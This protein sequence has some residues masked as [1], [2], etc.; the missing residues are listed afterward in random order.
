M[1]PIRKSLLVP[2][3]STG[4]LTALLAASDWILFSPVSLGI[5]MALLGKYLGGGLPPNV[6]TNIDVDP[7]Q[8]KILLSAFEQTKNVPF[9][10]YNIYDTV[11]DKEKDLYITK[12]DVDGVKLVLDLSLD[13]FETENKELLKAFLSKDYDKFVHE[14]ELSDKS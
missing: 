6:I 11:V 10:E 4:L 12:L 1:K 9:D 7:V 3:V 8:H 5:Y 13:I 2:V 14:C